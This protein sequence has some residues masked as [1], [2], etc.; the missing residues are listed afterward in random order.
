MSEYQWY[1]FLALDRPLTA[2]QMAELRDISSRA[3]IGPRRFW[4]EY[5]WGDLK[6]KPSKLME[7][8]FDA[9]LYFANWGTHE[10]MVRLP[11]ARVDAKALRPYFGG[12]AASLRVHGDHVTF[13]MRS[14]EHED[15]DDYEGVL[16]AIA[17]IRT[18]LLQG[19]L[20]AAYLAWLLRTEAE[21]ADTAPEPPVPPGLDQLTSA[22][23]T[24]CD[25]LG[26]DS[27]LVAAAARGS[28]VQDDG[29]AFRRW[30]KALSAKD[31][32]AW[33]DRAAGEPDLALGAELL[34]SFRKLHPQRSAGKPRVVGELRAIARELAAAREKAAK[35]R[36][37]KARQAAT[38]ARDGALDTVAKKGNAAWDEL[39]ALV[40][41]RQYA[42][43][44]QLAVDLRDLAR[45]DRQT[46]AFEEQ[47]RAMKKRQV[48]RPTFFAHWSRRQR[49]EAKGG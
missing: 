9:F 2:T 41:G 20:R 47:F 37:E 35:L 10:L 30:V 32:D 43:A 7:R 25:F 34:A 36:R 19:D 13:A 46:D 5:E 22:Q 6:A 28:A 31:K 23:Q 11:K 3:E 29:A 1:E 15:G 48:R 16:E 39:E 26:I 18:E 38:R 42:A 17:P 4:N 27:D 21:L 8:Y 40:D 14:E 33:L 12:D 44:V 45:R 24:L 49:E